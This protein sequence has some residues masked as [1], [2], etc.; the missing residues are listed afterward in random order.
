VSHLKDDKLRASGLKVTAP[1]VKILQLLESSAQR[2]L[3]A[4]DLYSKLIKQGDEVGLATVYRVLSQFV[5]AGLVVRH[6]FEGGSSVYELATED[7]HDHLV[8]IKCDQ[9][10]EF[11][12]EGIESRQLAIA[13]KNGFEVTDHSLII[14]G[15]CRSCQ[16]EVDD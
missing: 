6:N 7:H 5:T 4:E 14:Y 15:L 9:V 1:R 13:A 16:Q 2:H 12:D 8:C 3:S 11:L 10:T